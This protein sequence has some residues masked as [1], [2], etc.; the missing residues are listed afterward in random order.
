LDTHARTI[1][2]RVLSTAPY[3]YPP[4]ASLTWHARLQPV[5]PGW[6]NLAT[7]R[8]RLDTGRATRELGWRPRTDVRDA[9]V[10]LITGM[11]DSAGASTAP[12]QPR[13]PASARLAA[14]LTGRL[15]GHGNPY[16]T[17][18]RPAAITRQRTTASQVVR[19]PPWSGLLR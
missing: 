3:P 15:P 7:Q 4:A 5:E 14:M 16:S 9:L 6:I 10:E 11:A 17:R 19:G 2:V 1:E 18:E 8:R 12:L 13:P